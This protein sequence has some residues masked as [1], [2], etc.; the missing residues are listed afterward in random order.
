MPD[1]HIERGH[2]MPLKKAKDAAI[3]FAKQLEDKFDLESEW[4]GDTLHFKRAGAS[5]TMV[6]TKSDVTIDLK[7][8][9]LLSA[10]SSKIEGHI[11]DNLDKLFGKGAAPAKAAAKKATKK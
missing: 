9:F 4:E 10:F 8:G 11:N 7:L 3:D 1:I 2:T 5:G 6:L